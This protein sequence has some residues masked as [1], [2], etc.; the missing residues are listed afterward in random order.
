[1]PFVLISILGFALGPIMDGDESA[2]Q[3]KVAIVEHTSEQQEL[4]EIKKQF[5]EIPNINTLLP[6]HILKEQLF[7]S[8]EVKSFITLDEINPSE[9][10]EVK[11]DGIY[12]AIIEVPEHFTF[13]YD[14]SNFFRKSKAT[15]TNTVFE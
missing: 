4:E 5:G 2:L 8:E 12:D 15:R 13:Q 3:L 1:M 6:I 10:E 7:N 14:S 11:K 9:L